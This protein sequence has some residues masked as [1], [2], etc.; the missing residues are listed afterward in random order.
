MSSSHFSAEIQNMALYNEILKPHDVVTINPSGSTESVDIV[1]L[2]PLTAKEQIQAREK[3]L[4]YRALQRVE[5]K[6]R[7]HRLAEEACQVFG[8][9]KCIYSHSKAALPSEHGWWNDPVQIQRVKEVVE[10]AEKQAREKRRGGRAH[11]TDEK[12]PRAKG[13]GRGKGQRVASNSK[14][15][16]RSGREKAKDG[17]PAAK[18]VETP[19]VDK[20]AQE[21]EHGE[22]D[23]EKRG[24]EEPKAAPADD[25]NDKSGSA[26]EDREYEG[27]D[28]AKET[29]KIS[30]EPSA[31]S[32]TDST[33]KTDLEVENDQVSNRE[34]TDLESSE[35]AVQGAKSDNQIISV[36]Q[37]TP[38]G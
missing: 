28:A 21:H 36:V 15:K 33:S 17:K 25:S 11:R 35:P 27:S 26:T 30:T 24:A 22:A 18:D 7:N 37:G 3:A 5:R 6:E 29:V 34:V 1:Q 8:D 9:H 38:S 13:P 19:V 2:A 20:D 23:A 4:K 32:G 14:R 12:K 16:E 10:F 31:S